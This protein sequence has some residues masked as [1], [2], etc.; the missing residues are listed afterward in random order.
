MLTN[1]LPA[2][3]TA[4]AV[5]LG[6]VSFGP[7]A[8]AQTDPLKSTLQTQERIDKNEVDSQKRVDRIADETQSLIDEY[9]LV[10]RRIDSLRTY[11]AHLEKLIA[12]QQQEIDSIARQIESLETTNREVVPLMLRMIEALEKF[13]ELDLPFLKPERQARLASLRE[14]MDRADITTSE[15]YRRVMEGYQVEN[16]Y[17]RTIEAYTGTLE[18]EGEDRTVDFLRFGRITLMYQTQDRERRGYWDRNAQQWVEI[19]GYRRAI[20]DGLRIAR[21]QAA[22]DLVQIPVPAPEKAQ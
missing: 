9:R 19:D 22:P 7:A 15:K 8:S 14:I 21:K 6:L 17:G 20:T 10:T 16:E 12:S 18:L 1:R 3:V 11:N 13:V 2:A 4:C 5:I